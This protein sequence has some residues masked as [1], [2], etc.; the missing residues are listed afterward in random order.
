MI[1]DVKWSNNYKN[2]RLNYQKNNRVW[3]ATKEKLKSRNEIA[4]GTF[5]YAQ[6]LD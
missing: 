6:K 3:I 1:C 2:K 4:V 5:Q